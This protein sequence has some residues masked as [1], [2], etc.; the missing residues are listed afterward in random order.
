MYPN[1]WEKECFEVC[2]QAG[3]VVLPHEQ[4][5]KLAM[6]MNGELNNRLIQEIRDGKAPLKLPYL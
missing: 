5:S 1:S 3:N 6:T 2:E 4:T